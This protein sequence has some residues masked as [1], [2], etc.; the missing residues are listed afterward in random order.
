MMSSER[1]QD[2]S[3]IFAE[4]NFVKSYKFL[5]KI[6][7]IKEKIPK[8]NIQIFSGQVEMRLGMTLLTNARRTSQYATRSSSFKIVPLARGVRAASNARSGDNP[9]FLAK[10][11]RTMG[12]FSFFSADN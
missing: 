10:P 8:K 9:E 7:Q 5:K 4:K 11:Q 12:I 1:S 3:L 6:I 2:F